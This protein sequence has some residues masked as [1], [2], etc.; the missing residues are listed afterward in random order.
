[1]PTIMAALAEDHIEWVF[2]GPRDRIS[3]AG[4]HREVQ[5]VVQSHRCAGGGAWLN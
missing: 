2:P 5:E 3:F 1:M 4:V